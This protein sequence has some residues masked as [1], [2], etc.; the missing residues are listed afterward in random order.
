MRSCLWVV[1][2]AVA[3][4]TSITSAATMLPVLTPAD[5]PSFE[6]P[7][8]TF[9]DL[10]AP[11]WVLTGPTHL[12]NVPPFG[13]IPI[14]EGAGIF[15]NPP[16]VPGGRITNADGSQLAYIFANSSADFFSGQVMDHA[17]T[18]VIDDTVQAGETYTLT[19]GFANAQSAPP[20]DSVLTM[21][22]FAFDSGDSSEQL[23]ASQTVT[24][25]DLNGLTLTDF[26]AQTV[27]IAGSAIGK[28]IGMRISTHT[29]EKPASAT[30]QF[31]FDNVRLFVTPEPSSAAICTIAMLAM[32]G[33]RRA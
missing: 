15:E 5:N 10:T 7:D 1:L 6:S 12:V 19:I 31:D 9:I 21:S 22:L 25:A 17:F 2:I 28:Q 27:P 14:V 32:C 29:L 3:F 23:L 8:T 24:A 4:F 16:T 26:S 30:G 11:P 20:A 18:Q 13:L 33:R